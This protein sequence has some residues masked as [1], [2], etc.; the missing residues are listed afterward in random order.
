M[1]KYYLILLRLLNMLPQGLSGHGSSAKQGTLPMVAQGSMVTQGSLTRQVTRLE[2]YVAEKLGDAGVSTK[3]PWIIDQFYAFHESDLQLAESSR[4]SVADLQMQTNYL[5]WFEEVID[6]DASAE[7]QTKMA[8]FATRMGFRKTKHFDLHTDFQLRNTL[9]NLPMNLKG[10]PARLHSPRPGSTDQ[11]MP[12]SG[13]FHQDKD[14]IVINGGDSAT[15]PALALQEFSNPT[16][17]TYAYPDDIQVPVPEIP[18]LQIEPESLPPGAVPDPPEDIIAR[19]LMEREVLR[20]AL[21][22]QDALLI[23][24]KRKIGQEH[25]PLEIPWAEQETV[26]KLGAIAEDGD[27]F[28]QPQCFR[29]ALEVNRT[30]PANQSLHNIKMNN[31]R[32]DDEASEHESEESV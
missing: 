21:Q 17:P 12:Q 32:D 7:R 25:E 26:G 16:T 9:V 22:R 8:R 27:S 30:V 13:A 11:G 31:D 20:A 18:Q 23:D 3:N 29:P 19:V 10:L 6:G 14:D 2:A 5:S 24:M 4:F 15:S 28:L 1:T